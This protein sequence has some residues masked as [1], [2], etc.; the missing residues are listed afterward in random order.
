MD[1]GP[2][3]RKALPFLPRR[4]LHDLSHGQ[5]ELL[6]KLIIPSIMRWNRH[7]CARPVPRQH[8]VGNPH[9]YAL[10]IHGIDSESSGKHARFILR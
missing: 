4:R 2:V 8:V 10:S 9:R 3:P 6:R 5:F 1:R 7:D